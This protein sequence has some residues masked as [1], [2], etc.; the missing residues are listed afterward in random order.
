MVWARQGLLLAVLLAGCGQSHRGSAPST[1]EGGAASGS[2]GAPSAGAASLPTAGA[3]GVAA[4]GAAGVV[5]AGAAGAPGLGDPVA[6]MAAWRTRLAAAN[7]AREQRCGP[8]WSS[9]DACLVDA[10]MAPAYVRFFGGVDQDAYLAST[11]TLAAPAV[12]DACVTSVATTPCDDARSSYEACLSVLVPKAARESGEPCAY[13]SP[14]IQAPACAPGLVCSNPYGC[15]VCTPLPEPG[16]AGEACLSSTDCAAG[17]ACVSSLCR[18]SSTLSAEGSACD[19]ASAC[20]AGL[21]CAFDSQTCVRRAG[22][23]EACDPSA[24]ACLQDLTCVADAASGLATCRPY[25]RRGEACPRVSTYWD[26]AACDRSNWCLFATA[27]APTGTCGIASTAVGPC[28]R[29]ADDVSYYC[30]VGSYPD[31]DLQELGPPAPCTCVPLVELGGSCQSDVQCAHG[32]CAT[33]DDD[34]VGHCVPR[35]PEGAACAPN[36]LGHCASFRGC[37]ADAGTCSAEC[38]D[39]FG[40]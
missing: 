6:A 15:G 35:L 38:A 25:A 12:L 33:A 7:C 21:T 32:F 2:G 3:S 5:A 36:D 1:G 37:D 13:D 39:A 11:H 10:D 27:D 19:A 34:E 31:T 26:A 29:F 16:T 9:E 8:L 28:T 30:P 18:A 20:Q 22:E 4:A 40:R 23:D 24:Y 14:Y 17:L